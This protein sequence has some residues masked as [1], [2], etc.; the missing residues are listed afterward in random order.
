MPCTP[1]RAGSVTAATPMSPSSPSQSYAALV[2]STGVEWTAWKMTVRKRVRSITTAAVLERR[3]KDA[4]RREVDIAA[5]AASPGRV[6]RAVELAQAATSS[7]V[8]AMQVCSAGDVCGGPSLTSRE[9]LDILRAAVDHMR[10]WPPPISETVCRGYSRMP[11]VDS[12][13]CCRPTT[14]PVTKRRP[15]YWGRKG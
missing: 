9:G 7:E 6:R 11:G 2:A 3:N 14:L 4:K 1:F 5:A 12:S 10:A 13:V 15:Q 8:M